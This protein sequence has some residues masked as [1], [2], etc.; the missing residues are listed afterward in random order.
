MLH[1]WGW[2][3]EYL[4][5]QLKSGIFIVSEV[6]V[7]RS[8]PCHLHL[9]AKLLL[10]APIARSDNKHLEFGIGLCRIICLGQMAFVLARPTSFGLNSISSTC[11][12]EHENYM[13]LHTK[14]T[15]LNPHTN[16]E[17]K[18]HLP[19]GQTYVCHRLRRS[20]SDSEM[21]KYK[22]TLINGLEPIGPSAL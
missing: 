4:T 6:Y 14:M 10:S 19:S 13:A 11:L 12:F 7:K 22:K 16:C 15:T 18:Y 3:C 8:P 21:T 2:L 17:S 1:P 9:N 5:G 20:L